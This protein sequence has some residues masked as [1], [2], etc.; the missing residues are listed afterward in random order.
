MSL[1]ISLKDP[2]S[3]YEGGSLYTD[4]IT[5]NLGN[6]ANEAGIYEALWRPYR[7]R[8]DYDKGLEHS[9]EK[10]SSYEESVT[11]LAKD[12][13]DIIKKGL[14]DLKKRPGYYEKFNSPNGWG[15]YE[16]FVPFVEDYLE[17]LQEYPE[18]IV[19]ISR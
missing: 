4:N 16:H 10:E 5:H 2:T 15:R 19:I 7:L 6:M 1:D 18:A 14:E 12:I 17:A 3:T 13:I 11:I 8:K 9:Y